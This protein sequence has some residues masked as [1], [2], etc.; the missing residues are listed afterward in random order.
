MKF[1][2]LSFLALLHRSKVR[3]SIRSQTFQ[4]HQFTRMS[5]LKAFLLESGCKSKRF[6]IVLQICYIVFSI[7]SLIYIQLVDLQLN[8]FTGKLDSLLMDKKAYTDL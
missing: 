4:S 6:F 8:R 3:Y 7:N 5:I 1:S 2:R